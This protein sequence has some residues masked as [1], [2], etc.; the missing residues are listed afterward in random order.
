MKAHDRARAA[1]KNI[2]QCLKTSAFVDDVYREHV[3][4]F[5]QITKIVQ[6]VADLSDLNLNKHSIRS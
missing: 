1:I 4:D 3:D 5:Y 6:L 2:N